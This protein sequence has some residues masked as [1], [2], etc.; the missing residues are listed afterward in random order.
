MEIREQEHSTYITLSPVG[1]L[2]A[3]SSVFLDEKIQGLLDNQQYKIHVD[4]GDIPYISSAG[5][6]VFI[7]HVD[8]LT[9]QGGKFVVSNLAPNVAEVFKI[10]GLDQL[11]NLVLLDE[12]K[13]VETYF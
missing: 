10:L 8:E 7:S 9:R 1:D 5:L 11:E 12:G 2:D 13:S 6:G 4:A 3:N